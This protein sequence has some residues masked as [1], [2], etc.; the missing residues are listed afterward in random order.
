MNQPK[1][2]VGV[3]LC[4]NQQVLLGRRHGSHG[5]DTWCFPG[6]HLEFGE[7]PIDCAKRELLEE[8]GLAA[9]QFQPGPYTNDVFEKEERHYITLFVLAQYVGG[10]PELR[11]PSKC[12]EWRWFDWNKLPSPLFLPI[13]NLIRSGFS[14]HDRR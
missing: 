3:I 6:G 7:S 14:L 13:Q 2:G 12:A 4:D 5:A 10:I 8:T 9:S 11:E 1:V